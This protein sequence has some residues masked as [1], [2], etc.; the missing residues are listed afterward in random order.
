M[1]RRSS[2]ISAARTTLLVSL[3]SCTR[4]CC[5]S[6]SYRKSL[7]TIFS[8]VVLTLYVAIPLA[9]LSSTSRSSCRVRARLP[10]LLC[11]HGKSFIRRDRYLDEMNEWPKKSASPSCEPIR[12]YMFL[13]RQLRSSFLKCCWSCVG[14]HKLSMSSFPLKVS[15]LWYFGG[16]DGGLRLR[17]LQPRAAACQPCTAPLCDNNPSFWHFSLVKSHLVTA[18]TVALHLLY[19]QAMEDAGA[20]YPQVSETLRKVSETYTTLYLPLPRT[21]QLHADPY[22]SIFWDHRSL[23]TNTPPWITRRPLFALSESFPGSRLKAVSDAKFI[24]QPSTRQWHTRVCRTCGA[25]KVMENGSSWKVNAFACV[26][27]YSCSWA[28]RWQSGSIIGYGSMPC[29]L[30]KQTRMSEITKFSR[31]ARSSVVPRRLFLGLVL[32]RCSFPTSRQSINPSRLIQNYRSGAN[33][34]Y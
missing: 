23:I 10:R 13:R 22:R 3:A 15:R 33:K 27:I 18:P 11:E 4:V 21:W 30:I 9:R 2:S 12:L 7:A 17:I 25:Q 24:L 14:I 8:T 5:R 32:T 28:T 1:R 31:W 34:L 29:A 20:I 16:V 19:T 26:G 6:S